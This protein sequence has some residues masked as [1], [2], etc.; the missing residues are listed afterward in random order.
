MLSLLEFELYNGWFKSKV[1]SVFFFRDSYLTFRTKKL[2]SGSQTEGQI[3]WQ[4]SQEIARGA[5]TQISIN[6]ESFS[7]TSI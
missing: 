6:R 1:F 5:K 7:V 3:K 2:N 4:G